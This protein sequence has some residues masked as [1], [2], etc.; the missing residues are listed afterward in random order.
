MAGEVLPPLPLLTARHWYVLGLKRSKNVRYFVGRTTCTECDEIIRKKSVELL[1]ALLCYT[2]SQW[3]K[4]TR[5]VV[6]GY[7]VLFLKLLSPNIML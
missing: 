4:K 5:L 6:C 2:K 7:S 1:M 3:H